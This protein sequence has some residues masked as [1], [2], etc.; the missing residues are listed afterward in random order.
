[1]KTKEEIA[2]E[3]T[4]REV[5]RLELALADAR[6]AAEEAWYDYVH[7]SGRPFG[8]SPWPNSQIEGLTYSRKPTY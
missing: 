6:V 7:K 1:M 3:E 4:Q 8:E 5:H 2:M